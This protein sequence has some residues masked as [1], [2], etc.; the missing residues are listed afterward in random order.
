MRGLNELY[1]LKLRNA[2]LNACVQ[3][4]TVVPCA[5]LVLAFRNCILRRLKRNRIAG[6]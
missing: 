4:T 5:V 6:P 2:H 1:R 3:G